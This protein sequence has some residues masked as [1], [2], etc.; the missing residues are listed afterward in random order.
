MECYLTAP[1]LRCLVLH[2][3]LL[4]LAIVLAACSSD[5]DIR[6]ASDSTLDSLIKADSTNERALYERTVRRYYEPDFPGYLSD[7]QRLQ[8]LSPENPQ[9]YYFVGIGYYELGMNDSALIALRLAIKN[10]SLPSDFLCGLARA[11]S[12]LGNED[13]AIELYTLAITIDSSNAIY[14]ADRGLSLTKCWRTAEAMADLRNAL[15]LDPDNADARL[16]FGVNMLRSGR[17]REALE[18]IY[19]AREDGTEVFYFYLDASAALLEDGRFAEALALADSALAEDSTNI[20]A[21]LNRT[22][23]LIALKRWNAARENVDWLIRGEL[24]DARGCVELGDALSALGDDSTA[25]TYYIKAISAIKC[26][27]EQIGDLISE[28][29]LRYIGK[30]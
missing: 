27:D 3:E 24:P 16:N 13:A 28:R 2:I 15:V 9:Y 17:H 22:N 18:E 8:A 4:L 10:Q 11:L 21:G 6:S 1:H 20:Y 29:L 25:M 14:L 7:A 23:A 12:R 26:C 5:L 30:Q 19:T